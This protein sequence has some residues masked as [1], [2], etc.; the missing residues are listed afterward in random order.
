MINA[1]PPLLA[2]G[3]E[4]VVN[5]E[6]ERRIARLLMTKNGEA[7]GAPLSRRAADIFR[8][9]PPYSSGRVFGEL[10]VEALKLSFKRAVQRAGFGGLHPSAITCA[11]TLPRVTPT[12]YLSREH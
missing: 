7:R 4:K 8:A 12:A 3:S 10:T 5:V 6:L 1:D 2:G 11:N 9:L